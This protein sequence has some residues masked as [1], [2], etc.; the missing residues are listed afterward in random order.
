MSWEQ[1]TNNAYNFNDIRVLTKIIICICIEEV[2]HIFFKCHYTEAVSA[3]SQRS[4]IGIDFPF[5]IKGKYQI[6]LL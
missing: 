5:I 6:N 1:I 3:L 2:S 4:E